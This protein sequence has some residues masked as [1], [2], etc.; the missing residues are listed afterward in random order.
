[1][2]GAVNES[3]AHGYDPPGGDCSGQEEG[4]GDFG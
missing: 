1:L 3:T 4:G 2:R